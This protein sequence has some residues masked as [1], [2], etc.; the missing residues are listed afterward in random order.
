ME[1][2]P[3]F[4]ESLLRLEEIVRQLDDGKTDLDTALARYEEGVGL[5]KTCHQTLESARRKIDVLRGIDENGEP[6]LE[7]AKESDFKTSVG[8]NRP[9]A[10]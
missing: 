4:E 1:N 10:G 7:T 2:P 6:I 3:S 8:K 9:D 5:L